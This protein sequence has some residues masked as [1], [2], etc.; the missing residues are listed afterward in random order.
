MSTAFLRIV[1]RSSLPLVIFT[2]LSTVSFAA[3]ADRI[4]GALTSGQTVALRGNVHH[5][6]LPQYDKGPV[7][8]ALRMGTIT[9]MLSPTAAQQAALKQLVAQQQDPKSSHYHKWIT[10][11]QGADRFGLGQADIA[12][13]TAWR[14]SQ[15]LGM[16][17]PAPARHRAT[18]PGSTPTA[19]NHR[20]TT[21]S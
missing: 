8:P 11:E 17:G 14:K 18:F 15:G 21:T 9:L 5:K 2:F 13:I 16:I 7:D 20:S 1:R 12:K 3:T 4:S 19:T 10:P 6:A